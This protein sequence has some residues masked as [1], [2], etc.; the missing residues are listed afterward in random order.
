MVMYNNNRN[1]WLTEENNEISILVG[2]IVPQNFK[3]Y[4]RT[5]IIIYDF[6]AMWWNPYLH[7]KGAK[8]C[9]KSKNRHFPIRSLILFES[10]CIYHFTYPKS[11]HIVRRRHFFGCIVLIKGEKNVRHFLMMIY[12]PET[13]F[14]WA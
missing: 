4:N 5:R 2:Y 14:Y 10:P 9:L 3:S 7:A 8:T 13:S 12:R 11:N 1:C 6:F